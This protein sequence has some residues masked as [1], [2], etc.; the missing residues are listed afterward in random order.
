M[1]SHAREGAH[2]SGSLGAQDGGGTVRIEAHLAADVAEVWSALT[3]PVRLARWYGEIDGDLRAGGEYRARLHAS[4]WE[5]TG[6]VSVCEPTARLVIAARS[7]EEPTD[8]VTEIALTRDGD[9]TVVVVGQQGL[10][11]QLLAAYA[12]GLQVHVED[13]AAHLTGDARCDARSRWSELH[14]AYA[15]LA[16]DLA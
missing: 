16:A 3:D 10:P 6:R 11:I 1:T 12:A 9:R 14:P 5:G 4:G 7:L 13:L 8:H 2:I 15:R